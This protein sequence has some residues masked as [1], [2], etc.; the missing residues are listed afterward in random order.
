MGL[1]EAVARAAHH[2]PTVRSCSSA[3]SIT[4]GLYLQQPVLRD[5]A[6]GPVRQRGVSDLASCSA[7][8][9]WLVITL[10]QGF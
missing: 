2:A 5:L 7:C 9:E 8:S 6:D 1:I 3:R 4:V 10:I